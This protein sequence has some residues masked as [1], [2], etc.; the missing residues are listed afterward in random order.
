MGLPGAAAQIVFLAPMEA[1]NQIKREGVGNLP[2][3]PY[4]SM[5]VNGCV[6]ATYG[7]LLST[8]GIWLPNVTGA[9]LGFYY[10]RTFHKACPDNVYWL[11]GTKDLHV[12][13]GGLALAGVAACATMMPVATALN[14]LGIA[15]N[16]A[17]I[18]MF[19]GPLASIQHVIATKNTK[20]MPFAFTCATFVNC[21][22]WSLY[23]MCVLHDPYI[24]F[25][26]ML[27]FGSSCVQLSLFAKYGFAKDE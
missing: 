6:W 5:A 13:G 9:L 20:S 14:T 4:S 10:W 7:L 18:S 26:N 8:P 24:W 11:P 15:G 1:M 22:L 17:V 3:L 19:G 16:V 27:G 12:I 21:S 2:L 23:G 25:P